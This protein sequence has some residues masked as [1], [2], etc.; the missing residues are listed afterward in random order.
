MK[1]INY[2]YVLSLIIGVLF[3]MSPTQSYASHIMGG[4]LTFTCLGGNTYMM[5]LRLFRDCNGATLGN[6]QTIDFVS[7]SCGT[8][9]QN[10]NLVAGYPIIIT[11]LCPGEPDRCLVNTAQYGVHEYV[12]KGP[13]TLTGC[14]ANATDITTSWDLCCRNNAITT[15]GGNPGA[16]YISTDM[17]TALTPC[18]NS[19]DFL[20]SPVA[21]F[22]VNEPVNYNH[23]AS[24]PEND[25]L[26]FS[27]VD[28][29]SSSGTSSPYTGAF[30]GTNPLA[31]STG[32][33]ID[34]ITGGLQFT[35]NQIQVGVICVLVEE[36]RNGIKI[37]EVV[38]D[39]QF[40]II[41]CT[42]DLPVASGIDGTANINGT[43]GGFSLTVCAGDT[44]QFDVATYDKN[45]SD[46]IV[47]PGP[48]SIVLD[49]NQAISGASFVSNNANPPTGS[50][51]WVPT[52]ADVGTNIFTVDVKDDGCPINGINIY[53]YVISV[54]ERPELDAGPYQV[55]CSPGDPAP[56]AATY[57]SVTNPSLSA[58]WTPTT[59][60]ADPSATATTASPLVTTTYK[61]SGVYNNGCTYE[62]SV[63]VEVTD[64]IQLPALSDTTICQGSVQLDATI[65]VAIT[66][67]TTFVNDTSKAIPDNDQNGIRS[68]IN[69]SG[70][71]P[72]AMSATTIDSVCI[73]IPHVSST[74]VEVYLISPDGVVIELTSGNGGF[75]AGYVNTCFTPTAPS[76]VLTGAPPFTGS[77]LPEGNFGSLTGFATNGTWQLLV[78]DV[79]LGFTST[80]D[81]WSITF[82][83]PNV[84]N[85]A[86]TPTTN[87]SCSNCPNPLATPT[88]ST[89][90]TVTATNQNGCTDVDSVTI[91]VVDTLQA[92]IVNCSGITPNSLV[93]CWDSIPG[94]IGYEVNVDNNGWVAFNGP[95]LCHTVTGLAVSQTVNIQVRGL[96]NC[97]NTVLLIGTQN[98]TTAPCTL[99]GTLAGSPTNVSCPGG[100]DGA[101]TI[102]AT[103]GNPAYEFSMDNF[104]TSLP[105]GVFSNL[106]AGN[107]TIK[108]RDSF[109][110][111]DSVVVTITEP[112]PLTTTMSMDSVS[113]F[114]GTDG[115][116]SVLTT[117]GTGGYTYQWSGIVGGNTP[118]VNG[119]SA[120]KYYVTVTDANLC[121][122][123]DSIIV[124]QPDSISLTTTSVDVSCNGAGD[125]SITVIPSGGNGTYSYAWTGSA[126]TT[127]SAFNLN[128]GNYT[129]AVTD[130]KGCTNSIADTINENSLIVLDTAS[131]PALCHTSADGSAIVTVTGGTGTYTYLWDVNAGNQVT[132]TAFNVA[133]GNYTVTVTDSDGCSKI[134]TAIVNAPLPMSVTMSSTDANCHNTTDGT[135][136]VIASGGVGNY[137][138]A[139]QNSTDITA[140]ATGLAAGFQPVTV[141]D[142]NGCQIVDSVQVMGPTPI[143]I[144]LTP[145]AVTCFGNSDG[146]ITSTV[147]G[148]DGNY[149]YAWTNTIQTTPNLANIGGGNYTVTVTDGN[150]CFDTLS[151]FVPEPVS[152]VITLDSTDISCFNGNDGTAN[153]VANGGTLPYIFLW[154]PSANNQNTPNAINLVT[155]YQTVTVTDALGCSAVD[156][157]FINQPATGV[158]TSTSSTPLNC[159][160]DGSGTATV[161]AVGG[162]GNYT[163]AWDANANNQNTA[164]ATNLQANTYT[165]TV[166]DVNGCTY[167]DNVTVTEPTSLVSTTGATAASCNG[168]ADGTVVVTPTGGVGNY[169][170]AWSTT[171]TIT[172]SLATGLSAGTYNVTVTDGNG[173]TTTNT[174]IVTEPNGMT[175][176]MSMTMVS[177][178]GGNDGTASVAVVGGT[179]PYSYVWS[180]S[181]S[182]IGTANNLMAG[183]HYVTVT[184]ANGCFKVDSIQ[185]TEP[186]ELTV[187]LTNVDVSCFG[188]IDG[189]ATANPVGG[190]GNYI[191]QWNTTP[192]QT[193]ATA[194]NLGTGNY[195]VT[196]TD[197]NGCSVIGSVFVGQPIS[198]VTTTMSMTPVS[199]NNGRDGT[200]QVLAVGGA[201]NYTYQWSDAQTTPIAT[202]LS[203]GTFTVTVTDQNGC[204]VTNTITVNQP[205]PITL[206][207]GQEST[208][209][210]GGSDGKATV[211]GSGGV[212][213]AN[214][215][216]TYLWNSAPIQQT[217]ATATGLNGGQTYTVTVTDQ[218]GCTQTT[219]VTIDQPTPVQLTTVQ[220]N[221][222]CNNFSD[223]TA[224][225]TAGGG[226]PGYTYQWDA[227]AAN[228]T[229][230]MASNLSVGMFTVTVTDFN[231]CTAE[232]TVQITEPP[233]L[234]VSS[235][236]EDVVCKGENTGGATI[237]AAGGTPW[238]S[239]QWDANANNR[240]SNIVTGLA[241]GTYTITMTDA[242]GCA[243][244]ETLTIDE[245]SEAL[246]ATLNPVDASCFGD[247]D[248]NVTINATGGMT[249]Y[250]YN[251]EGESY[252]SSNIIT[253]LTANEYTVNVRDDLGC[254]YTE[255][256]TINEPGE[257]IVDAGPD[258]L[259]EYGEGQPIVVSVQNGQ[260]PFFY[261]WTPADSSLS[262]TTCPVPLASPVN[263]MY[264]RVLVTDAKGC[265][266]E[267][268][269][270]V[271]VHKTRQ[272][273]VATGFSP[274]NDGVNDYLF[275][276]GGDETFTVVE[277]NV[278]DRWG[279]R[280]FKAENTVL[281]DPNVGWNGYFKGQLM[282]SGVYGWTATIEFSDGER[283]SYT[284]NTTLIK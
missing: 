214:G 153:V 158:S 87:L 30:N 102:N 274:N 75:G 169:T 244:T 51:F 284:G 160:G 71:S 177:C 132:D 119:L 59:A 178:F 2:T 230:A 279:E 199:C 66:G 52:N 226:T 275:V 220:T 238:Y 77:F 278:Y 60:L 36:Y 235:I 215:G 79:A 120:D 130:F 92:P 85:Y 8:M 282:N 14:W 272:V 25:S 280:V 43:T 100:S 281:N 225:V 123:I 9:T 110:C 232:T 207:A 245:P 112:T 191:Y 141:T 186:T 277:F 125:G 176:T 283:L 223:G 18:N 76:S 89:T 126:S 262:C 219:S 34:P 253:G 268:D 42:N 157:I 28:C 107:Y 217:T 72:A 203:A 170:Y 140:T 172:D 24:D 16:T 15:L 104:A 254:I 136:T 188:G 44:I 103:G 184:D 247:R 239:F 259:I 65:P 134:I 47:V 64:G 81:R 218:N 139:W 167:I 257:I 137:T 248:G 213:D 151:T 61:V 252:G 5:Q 121:T 96:T 233:V 180:P 32:V 190:T 164:T 221:I 29:L 56:I 212:P 33:I 58:T 185:V 152:L 265:Q 124:L 234:S 242:N 91:L 122:T 17:N 94:A 63:I 3:T 73:T 269:V 237:L 249:P 211:I 246:A 166:T 27:L 183:W 144:A 200:A 138:Y 202:G 236:T 108:V 88:N 35:P 194:T 6:T 276:Q 48:Q 273:Y 154:G 55:T 133:A 161:T 241:A 1:R 101:F 175:L 50:F 39:M 38:R 145:A 187:S 228:Q 240:T 162:S 260:I 13:V 97:A 142:G 10:L 216:Y 20:N 83:D 99:D 129:V 117:G 37:G 231:G 4:D 227:N 206:I 224:T 163:Y 46:V 95:G 84:I 159:N 179:T 106:M 109:F 21:F 118:M 11:P 7:P 67:G 53:S 86:W 68:Y 49:W 165:V 150:G 182:I 12:Y 54:Q 147:S 149:T 201:G 41:P 114:D 74:D 128:G 271:R 82:S 113:C 23:G 19:P 181:A 62:D 31:T 40:T 193:N 196:V 80:I 171:P 251:I 210:F 155:G 250:Q 173:C 208:S 256:I 111:I 135:A 57:T 197:V 115:S 266:G 45:I 267:D 127:S 222:T 205:S 70:V 22:C 98:C 131:I 195:V 261:D 255:N 69:V 146:A 198:G 174:A 93:F 156:S 189:S 243:I 270:A 168:Y 263:D 204:F 105:T 229:T 258:L 192:V 148:G 143:S 264:Y 116:A 209:C 90:Y 26:V 78:K